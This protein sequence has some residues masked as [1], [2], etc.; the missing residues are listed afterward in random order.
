MKA[1]VLVV[2][3]LAALVTFV[4]SAQA[5]SWEDKLKKLYPAAKAEGEIIVNSARHEELGGKEGLA[6]FNKRFPGIKLTISGI[7]G[8]KLASVVIAESKAGR[9]SIDLFRSDPSR[10]E[11]LAK[12][13]LLEKLDI[14]ALTDQ[15]VRTFFDSTFVKLSDHI[16]NFVYNTDLVKEAD[17]PKSYE[18]LLNPK[19]KRRIALDARG[20]Q[21]SHLLSRKVWDEKKFWDYVKALKE[22]NPIWTARNTEAMA[23]ITSGEAAIGTGSYAAIENLKERGAP[24]GFLFLSPALSQVRGMAILKGAPHP[25]ASKL[26]L[27]WLMS[28]EGLEARDKLAVG[29]IEPGTVAYK[30]V[31]AANAEVVAEDKIENILDRLAVQKKVTNEWGVYKTLRKKGK[32]RKKKKKKE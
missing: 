1:R 7:A 18:D 20:G 25:N 10:A 28:P 8:S 4:S 16:T 27:G 17:K 13:G 30:Q 26:F 6:K 5:A 9:V 29:V 23:K 22:Q 32:K 12:R 24:V 19:W 21:I 15:Q 3:L 14:S 31:K 2:P 11:P